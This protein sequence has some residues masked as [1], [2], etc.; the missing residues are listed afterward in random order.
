MR[1]VIPVIRSNDTQGTPNFNVGRK[2]R[3]TNLPDRDSSDNE[4]DQDDEDDEEKNGEEA[5]YYDDAYTRPER[6]RK[7]DRAL[8]KVPENIQQSRI[9]N[10]KLR[11]LRMLELKETKVIAEGNETKVK[12]VPRVSHPYHVQNKTNRKIQFVPR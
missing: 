10:K 11:F 5:E 2:K 9:L 7:T 12:I 1:Q 3:D 8:R 4:D 6:A